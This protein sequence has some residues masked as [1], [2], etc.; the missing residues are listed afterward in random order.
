MASAL[1]TLVCTMLLLALHGKA[2]AQSR[3]D[4]GMTSAATVLAD[5]MIRG[6]RHTMMEDPAK[7]EPMARTYE[8]RLR[9]LPSSL[10]R[11]VALAKLHWMAGEAATR[12]L[13][14]AAARERLQ[15]ARKLALQASDQQTLADVTVSVASLDEESGSPALAIRGYQGAFHI[16]QRLGNRRSQSITLQDL[17]SL[18]MRANDPVRGARYIQQAAAVYQEEPALLA[19]IHGTLGSIYSDTGRRSDAHTEYAAGALLARQAA[20]PSLEMELLDSDTQL[21]LD[22]RDL[23]EARRVNARADV[24]AKSTPT[25]E[26]HLAVSALLATALDNHPVGRD[27][28]NRAIGMVKG[29]DAALGDRRIHEL[30]FLVFK[31]LGDTD[32]ALEQQELS[33]RLKDKSVKASLD[34]QNA[35][36]AAQFDYANQNLRIAKLNSDRLRRK[37]HFQR[38]ALIW[39]C[40][41]G[42]LALAA[43]GGGLGLALLG[44]RRISAVNY[45]LKQSNAE[46]EQALEEVVKRERSEREAIELAE[47]DALTTLPNRR[48]LR[49]KLLRG[50]IEPGSQPVNV[51][52]MLMDLDRFK[53]INDIHGHEVGDLLLVEVANRLRAL[54]VSH[55]AKPA[56][57]GGDEFVIVVELGEDGSADEFAAEA[58]RTLARPFDIDGR[59]LTIGVSIGLSR[60]GRDGTQVSDLLRKA[61][62]AMYEAKRSGRNT[63]RFFD[64][65]MDRWLQDRAQMEA[66]LRIAVQIG[67]IDVHYQPIHCFEENRTTSFEALARWTHP[68]RGPVA[69]DQFIPLAEEA[70]IISELTNQV[71][72]QACRAAREWPSDVSVSV[73]LS[74]LLLGD[75][76]IG[77][78]VMSILAKEGLAPHRLVMEITE[79]AVIGDRA[80]AAEVINAF[81]NSGIRVALDDFGKGHSSLSQLHELAFDSLKLD[82]SFVRTF[83]NPDSLKI[84]T[85]VAGLARAMNLPVTAEGIETIHAAQTAQKLGFGFGQGYLFGRPMSAAHAKMLAWASDRHETKGTCSPACMNEAA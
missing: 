2:S 67:Q 40:A 71:L 5:E 65:D 3:S 10:A 44:R 45:E 57:L 26:Y 1:R 73:N 76:W 51:A 77:P 83:D 41:T 34:A 68:L 13:H 37:T 35:L 33:T 78:R 48:N 85:A 54:C 75:E 15:R 66:D 80:R 19:T 69:P 6:A 20:M 30:A 24:L 62:I 43:L 47:H 28:I 72:L 81:R 4:A 9:L 63:F 14:F 64:D 55:N 61:D 38:V 59:R 27:L 11:T 21:L 23:K 16:F 79:T 25:S 36:L 60:Y 84:S 31:E 50:V 74:P 29:R 22:A 53:P 52:L 32:S 58:I 49:T 42:T 39:A 7:V 46:L 56:R 8:A 12:Q 18:Y 82:S 17:G 70:G